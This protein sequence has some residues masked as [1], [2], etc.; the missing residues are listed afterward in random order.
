MTVK[1]YVAEKLME[2]YGWDLDR[3]HETPLEWDASRDD[4]QY[5]MAL[6]TAETA[7]HATLEAMD[8]L[9][10]QEEA[11]REVLFSDLTTY[12]TLDHGENGKDI[13][14]SDVDRFVREAKALNIP[15]GTKL[16]GYL[17]LMFDKRRELISEEHPAASSKSESEIR[18]LEIDTARR[19]IDYLIK[20]G[21]TAEAEKVLAF[22]R[23]KEK[24]LDF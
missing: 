18:Q 1:E 4:S 22:I 3:K 21:D 11:Q 15:L 10:Q 23:E 24:D 6:D 12:L 8:L 13:Y 9:E 19:K 20:Q 5:A 16:E 2:S 14:L 17:H 7:I